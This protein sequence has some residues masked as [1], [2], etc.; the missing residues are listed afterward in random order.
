MKNLT[1]AGG[2]TRDAE[3]RR[4]NDGDP[5][6][7]FSVAVDDGYGD[8][9]RTIYFDCAM[10][11]KRGEKIAGF[12]VKG[13]KV[14]VS[15]ELSTRE[16]DGKTYLTVRVADVDLMGKPTGQSQDRETTAQVADRAQ[17]PAPVEEDSIPF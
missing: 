15:G 2:L 14:C 9:K 6:L 17:R 8:K 1:I 11:G 7:S 5:I 3:L 12:L 13:Q 16:H 10:F 4:T